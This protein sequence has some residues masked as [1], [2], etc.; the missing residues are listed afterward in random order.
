LRVILTF[1]EFQLDSDRFELRRNGQLR[2]VEPKVFDLMAHFAR[3]PGRVFSRE[4]LIASVW[5][6]RVVSDETVSTCIKNARKAVGDSGVT[7]RYIKTVR[8]RGFQFAADVEQDDGGADSGSETK[9]ADAARRG[10]SGPSLL[11]VPFRPLSDGPAAARL[12]DGVCSGL[13]TILTRI[14][15]LR[16]S[17]QTA[18]YSAGD[19]TPSARA[20]HED[21]GVDYV[22]EGT[23]DERDGGC[24]INVQLSDA[25]SGSSLRLR[26]NNSAA[27]K[28]EAACQPLSARTLL[29]SR[30]SSWAFGSP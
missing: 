26:R 23:L 19:V 6:G 9:T 18:R 16:L 11:V 5:R 20:I 17:S 22:L 2:K 29:A 21:V 7:Q 8:G 10:G 28:N 3:N 30:N 24:R 14:P 27:V 15:L 12:A 1:G 13:G 25:K 4:E